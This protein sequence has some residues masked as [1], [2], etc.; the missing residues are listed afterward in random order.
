MS[1]EIFK[2]EKVFIQHDVENKKLREEE[3]EKIRK[4]ESEKLRNEDEQLIK[5]NVVKDVTIKESKDKK[6]W[7]R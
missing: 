4:E 7:R 6:S 5:N 2:E 3:S 1:E